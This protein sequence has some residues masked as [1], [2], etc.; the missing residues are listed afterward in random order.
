MDTQKYH[1]WN[2]VTKFQNDK[3]LAVKYEDKD[4]HQLGIINL[5]GKLEIIT[6]SAFKHL[7]N[8][9]Y[10][11]Y[12]TNLK[13][14]NEYKTEISESE[15][16]EINVINGIKCNKKIYGKILLV[17]EGGNIISTRDD[18]IMVENEKIN[19]KCCNEPHKFI[20]CDRY[21]RIIH[22]C[23]GCHKHLRYEF[24]DNKMINIYQY[25]YRPPNGRIETYIEGDVY[26]YCSD[27]DVFVYDIKTGI[28][29]L[30]I[31]N[32]DSHLSLSYA[33]GFIAIGYDKEKI[34]IYKFHDCIT[35][36]KLMRTITTPSIMKVVA[37]IHNPMRIVIE[38][39]SSG[40]IEIIPIHHNTELPFEII[41][42]IL[43]FSDLRQYLIMRLVT[44]S[45]DKLLKLRGFQVRDLP[46][47]LKSQKYDLMFITKL[48]NGEI[49]FISHD[50]KTLSLLEKN[51][52][53]ETIAHDVSKYV[54]GKNHIC[55]TNVSS[56]N[57]YIM[58][59]I[60]THQRITKTVIGD[61]LIVLDN[62]SIV[63]S[64]DRNIFMD[65]KKITKTCC[66]SQNLLYTH[67]SYKYVVYQCENC[68]K[69]L[70]YTFDSMDNTPTGDLYFSKNSWNVSVTN[71]K[72]N[73][74]ILNIN[75]TK[76]SHASANG[77]VAIGHEHNKLEIYQLAKNNTKCEL[78][79]TIKN[80]YIEKVVAILDNPLRVV[81]VTC[82]GKC[83]GVEINPIE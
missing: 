83:G 47:L 24:D 54:C 76:L 35:K 52:N 12:V 23:I 20:W 45:F 26:A 82:A 3:I 5:D 21:K 17:L 33:S 48:S 53:L 18:C 13:F 68:S 64:H 34:E 55:Y 73:L 11:C 74:V 77:F 50:M 59:D 7:Y 16:T 6:I 32:D 62:G 71:E 61:A 70:K 2:F 44:H 15:V 28:R 57:N 81:S 8:S 4:S 69:C 43:S 38:M 51:G 46:K 40:D 72:N 36:C 29:L 80:P 60:N 56:V 78:M 63:S 22:E 37:V 58:F 75:G 25:K 14:A 30:D 42:H 27:T 10:V 1:G 31:T 9:N 79:K 65:N 49:C 39:C 19:E 67:T 66:S 41:N